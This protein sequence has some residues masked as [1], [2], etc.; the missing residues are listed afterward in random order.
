MPPRQFDFA[1]R[2]R[3]VSEE[4]M[5]GIEEW[6]MHHPQATL[7]EIEA[8][9]DERLAELRVRMLQ[10]VALASQTADVSHTTGQDR[11]VCPHCGTPVEPRGPCER[12][13]TTHQGKTLR[14]RRSYVRC[15]A[16][17]VGFFPPR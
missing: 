2:W 12:Q 17:Q 5:A 9:V 14:L 3:E 10:D 15:P 8:S 4:I 16:C 11:P 6:R 7:R 1:A 13:V